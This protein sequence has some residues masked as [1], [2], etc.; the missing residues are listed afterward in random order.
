MISVKDVLELAKKGLTLELQQELME[1]NERELMLRDE[2]LSLKEKVAQLQ[3]QIEIQKSVFYEDKVYWT[4]TDSGSKDGPFCQRCYDVEK[5]LIR[6]Q[7]AI[8]SGTPYWRCF[9]CK[10]TYWESRSK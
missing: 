3:K 8:S 5:V 4:R 6:L 2:N 9:E 10:G 1:A 7:P